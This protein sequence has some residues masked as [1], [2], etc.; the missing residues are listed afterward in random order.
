M[1][2]IPAAINSKAEFDQPSGVI[3]KFPLVVFSSKH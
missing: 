3:E 2:C 1:T